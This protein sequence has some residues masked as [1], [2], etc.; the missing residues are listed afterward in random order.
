[1]NLRFTIELDG[2]MSDFV[3]TESVKGLDEEVLRISNLL[4]EEDWSWIPGQQNGETVRVIKN[5]PIT[6]KENEDDSYSLKVMNT[7]PIKMIKDNDYNKFVPEPLQISVFPNPTTDYIYVSIGDEKE[8]NDPILIK[9][10]SLDGREIY[11]RKID[12]LM[13]WKVEKIDLAD[14]VKGMLIVTITQG[15]Y[16]VEQK[17]LVQ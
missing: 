8:S 14:D 5:I 6:F 16:S 10:V 12:G 4:K 15:A 17:V 9:V 3:I 1:M 2:T 7:G 11:E 13:K